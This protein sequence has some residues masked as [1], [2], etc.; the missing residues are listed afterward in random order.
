VLGP[1]AQDQGQCTACVAYAVA[2]AAQSAAAA[3]LQVDT[4][5]PAVPFP[6]VRQLFF[7]GYSE[8]SKDA[9]DCSNGWLL[10][11]A[12]QLIADNT[13]FKKGLAAEACM[14]MPASAESVDEL[15]ALP[16]KGE[17][18][19]VCLGLGQSLS[20]R[21][22]P[23]RHCSE[24][25]ATIQLP[26]DSVQGVQYMTCRCS[27]RSSVLPCPLN[28]ASYMMQ[29]AEQHLVIC[30]V[31]TV[32]LCR[33]LHTQLPAEVPRWANSLYG[34]RTVIRCTEGEP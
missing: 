22:L 18:Q 30:H 23:C 7:C 29:H 32:A 4:T 16:L 3:A 15:N 13:M 27:Q 19:L 28:L 26:G 20:M 9:P 25:H 1:V 6:S 10:R 34:T 14:P 33:N 8:G 24:A 21:C 12:L 5:D 31:Y 2:A 11:P 17:V